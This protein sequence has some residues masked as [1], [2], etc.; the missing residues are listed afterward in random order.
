MS[1]K[2]YLLS[3]ISATVLE[4]NSSIQSVFP[5][6]VTHIITIPLAFDVLLPC[7]K[8]TFSFYFFWV[9]DISIEISFQNYDISNSAIFAVKSLNNYT[10]KCINYRRRN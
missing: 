8:N 6:T 4:E 10:I 1:I 3:V 2:P 5:K 7:K 9:E